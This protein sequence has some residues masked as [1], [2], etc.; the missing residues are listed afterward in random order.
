MD[1]RL[2]LL[3]SSFV[4]VACGLPVFAQSS[5]GRF[6]PRVVHSARDSMQALGEKSSPTGQVQP[7]PSPGHRAKPLDC[8]IYLAGS[9]TFQFEGT[10]GSLTVERISND[11]VF[12][13]SGPLRLVLWMSQTPYPSAGYRAMTY[14]VGQLEPGASFSNVSSGVIAFSRPPAGCYYVTL[15]LEE[16]YNGAWVYDDYDQA[17][18]VDSC[19][20]NDC[21][22]SIGG[23]V[24]TTS[25]VCTTSATTICLNNSR[26]SVRV[27]WRTTAGQSGAATAIKYTA[28]SGFYWFF[29]PDNI[30]VLLKLLNGCG[31]NSRYWVFAAAT[32]DVEYTIRVTDTKTGKVKTYFHAA[33]TPA[34]AITDTN[35]FDTCP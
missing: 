5:G 11:C 2:G 6:T 1:K 32:T 28:D 3:L 13:R 21:R 15:V 7:D 17:T 29:G 10:S 8:N 30:E 18:S 26:F 31:L 20:G 16:F 22:L 27:D 35:A 4:A 23:A 19:T 9:W 24:C 14:D 33:G 34:P 12:T 25:S